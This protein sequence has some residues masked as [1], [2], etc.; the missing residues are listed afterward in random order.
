MHDH[1]NSEISYKMKTLFISMGV[2]QWSRFI[3]LALAMVT[4]AALPLNGRGKGKETY[5]EGLT[6][7]LAFAESEIL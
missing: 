6:M 4:V 2:L 7:D 5:G 1:R 3:T